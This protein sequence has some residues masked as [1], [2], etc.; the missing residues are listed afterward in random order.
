M[1]HASFES[2]QEPRADDLAHEARGRASPAG[3]YP[4]SWEINCCGLRFHDLD[5]DPTCCTAELRQFLRIGTQRRSATG[6]AWCRPR[7]VLDRERR[8]KLS[9]NSTAKVVRHGAWRSLSR[10]TSGSGPVPDRVESRRGVSRSAISPR[11]SRASLR[12]SHGATGGGG[13][14]DSDL[15]RVSASCQRSRWRR[16]PRSWPR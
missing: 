4:R 12:V 1:H 11:A 5:R 2:S 6:S 7:V 13:S 8:P 10:E 14:V 15:R 3:S 16:A 9:R